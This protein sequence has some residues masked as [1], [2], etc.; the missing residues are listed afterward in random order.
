MPPNI[1]VVIQP[2]PALLPLGVN[3]RLYRQGLQGWP[4]QRLKQIP[5]TGP[6][7][8]GHFPVQ[9]IPQR[10]DRSV[11]CIETEERYCQKKPA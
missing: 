8:P 11:Q 5:T 7:M 10:A 4:V 3:V 2:G 9:L 1:N 6:Q